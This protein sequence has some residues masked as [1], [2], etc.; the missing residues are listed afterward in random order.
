MADVPVPVLRDIFFLWFYVTV[1]R[2]KEIDNDAPIPVARVIADLV[3]LGNDAIVMN[4]ANQ[5]TVKFFY[6]QIQQNDGFAT[7]RAA[8]ASH[9]SIGGRWPLDPPHPTGAALKAVFIPPQ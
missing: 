6:N 2:L 4:D 8:L 7:V 5:T 1:T 9:P 3:Q